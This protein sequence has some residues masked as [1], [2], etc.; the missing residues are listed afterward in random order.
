MDL[1]REDSVEGPLALLKND[2]S[3]DRLQSGGWLRGW[4][5]GL[6]LGGH[7]FRNGSC[8]SLANQ[9]TSLSYR[10]SGDRGLLC[11]IVM[12]RGDRKLQIR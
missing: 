4:L 5:C 10:L 3:N 6:G 11:W 1:I 8:W 2:K 12:Q 9:A 7:R